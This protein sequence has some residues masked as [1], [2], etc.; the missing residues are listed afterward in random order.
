[1]RIR[2]LLALGLLLAQPAAAVEPPPPE[3]AAATPSAERTASRPSL[4]LGMIGTTGLALATRRRPR[5]RR[6][7]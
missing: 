5:S 7:P 4:V 6:R 1:M 2:A 3:P